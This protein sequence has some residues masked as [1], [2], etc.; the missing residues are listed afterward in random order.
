MHIFEK[1]EDIDWDWVKER[2]PVD[3]HYD[4][5]FSPVHII[6]EIEYLEKNNK[7]FGK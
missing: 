1:A 2:I 6:D 5:R 7:K 3:Y 4:G